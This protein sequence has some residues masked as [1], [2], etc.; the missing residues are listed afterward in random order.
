M[1]W[2]VFQTTK[3]FLFDTLLPSRLGQLIIIGI[4]TFYLGVWDTKWKYESKIAADK[5]TADYALKQE[6]VRQE[7]ATKEIKE[8]ATRRI[9]DDLAVQTDMQKIIDDYEKQ[10]K[11]RP[12]AKV[13]NAISSC[14]IDVDYARVLQQLSERSAKQ[15][16]AAR[17]SK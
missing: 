7:L 15:N 11:E 14:D 2:V 1:F 16:R 6:K 10:T 3:S 13:K 9:E 12:H 17:R 4:T 5:A 8:A